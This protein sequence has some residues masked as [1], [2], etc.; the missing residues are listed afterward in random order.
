MRFGA[1]AVEMGLSTKLPSSFHLPLA[2]NPINTLQGYYHVP[3]KNDD[4]NHNMDWFDPV[5]GFVW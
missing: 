3:D 4:S 5:G 1:G 2:L